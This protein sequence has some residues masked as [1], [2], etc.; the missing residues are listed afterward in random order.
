LSNDGKTIYVGSGSGDQNK[1]AGGTLPINIYM[2]LRTNQVRV[3][4]N[5]RVE[6]RQSNK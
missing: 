3:G 4:G 5:Y 2:P 6:F 1:D